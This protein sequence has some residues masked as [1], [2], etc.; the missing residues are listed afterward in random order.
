MQ[1]NASMPTGIHVGHRQDTLSQ[2]RETAML[3][4]GVSHVYSEQPLCVK[5]YGSKK[6]DWGE[7]VWITLI[8]MRRPAAIIIL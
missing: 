8:K 5:H 6:Q 1:C 4:N 3:S 2:C 7:N